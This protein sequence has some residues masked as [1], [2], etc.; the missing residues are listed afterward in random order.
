MTIQH[1][2]DLSAILL[3][4]LQCAPWDPVGVERALNEIWQEILKGIQ[5]QQRAGSSLSISSL[6]L[7][8]IRENVPSELYQH[9]AFVDLLQR[10]NAF[11]L[12]KELVPF[13]FHRIVLDSVE[14]V[15]SS[16]EYGGDDNRYIPSVK[17]LLYLYLAMSSSEKSH[18]CELLDPLLINPHLSPFLL[19][20]LLSLATPSTQYT[21][22]SIRFQKWKRDFF[23][24]LQTGESGLI[25]DS[26]SMLLYPK[27]RQLLTPHMQECPELLP[28][29]DRLL[30][31]NSLQ[32]MV[33]SI[34][35]IIESSILSRLKAIKDPLEKSN[36][37]IPLLE[38]FIEG[39]AND[40][41]LSTSLRKISL[42]EHALQQPLEAS[43][44]IDS[45]I[46]IKII[47]ALEKY[48]LSSIEQQILES[49]L[50]PWDKLGNS[51]TMIAFATQLTVLQQ[52]E[53]QTALKGYFDQKTKIMAEEFYLA[54]HALVHKRLE[55]LYPQNYWQQVIAI[56]E[57]AAF[58]SN[59]L[60]LKKGLLFFG[61]W[62]APDVLY[63]KVMKIYLPVEQQTL[64]TKYCPETQTS[65]DSHKKK[66]E[67]IRT[68]YKGTQELYGLWFHLMTLAAVDAIRVGCSWEQLLL[69]L[70]R[71]RNT[72]ALFM[73]NIQIL[74]GG[75]ISSI[76]QIQQANINK[77]WPGSPLDFG[78]PYNIP[79]RPNITSLL[80]PNRSYYL[81][82][83]QLLIHEFRQQFAAEIA[84]LDKEA[85]GSQDTFRKV[86]VFEFKGR[87]IQVYP[88]LEPGQLAFAITCP[89]Y[90][91]ESRITG[92]HILCKW[93]PSTTFFYPG[94]APFRI[95]PFL[96]HTFMWLHASSSDKQKM[97][98]EQAL[99]FLSLI[100]PQ[101]DQD[102][103]EQQLARFYYSFSQSVFYMRGSAIIGIILVNT[104]LILHGRVPPDALGEPRNMDC[105]AMCHTEKEFTTA[106][107]SWIKTGSF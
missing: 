103:F 99:L 1:L 93:P 80:T 85:T 39:I 65:H 106:F 3:K 74:R 42:L 49:G 77:D 88:L 56:I 20:L 68:H 33:E 75:M 81:K 104:F 13:V 30:A 95:Q 35:A 37:K 62:D 45:L 16:I 53:S 107:L 66:Q 36:N 78:V 18:L 55:Q 2:Q 69:L 102:L 52:N 34:E 91:G 9:E 26:L 82:Q 29:L 98:K 10:K 48:D 63:D 87:E 14:R 73:Q 64:W 79:N 72:V 24:G 27:L 59:D 40:T 12:I 5:E 38:E 43:I 6:A 32:D 96:S 83:M 11:D 89:F 31:I 46:H 51:D 70:G 22:G 54:F 17:T 92:T 7:S 58:R 19:N 94:H 90:M 100:A 50:E 76:T 71:Y 41:E 67:W 105:E 23:G 21:I 60:F 86:K 47:L 84:S 101:V 57:L 25:H 61:K 28:Y 8:I 4:E 97:Q 44:S 15:A